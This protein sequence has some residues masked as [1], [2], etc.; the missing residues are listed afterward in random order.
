MHFKIGH[1]RQ[2]AV[3]AAIRSHGTPVRKPLLETGKS[4]RPEFDK[5]I[6]I[7]DDREPGASAKGL[8][9]RISHA[10]TENETFYGSNCGIGG[11]AYKHPRAVISTG[12]CVY[13]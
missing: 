9:P 11:R 7:V 13:R 8:V 10:L 6:G 12:D 5:G 1:L 4:H 2:P 3:R